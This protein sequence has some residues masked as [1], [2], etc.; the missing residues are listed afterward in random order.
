MLD[1]V[2][3]TKP[4]RKELVSRR[5]AVN[6]FRNMPLTHRNTFPLDTLPKKIP[7]EFRLAYHLSYPEGK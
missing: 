5:K 4:L 6:P 1:I 2:L 3:R 7:G